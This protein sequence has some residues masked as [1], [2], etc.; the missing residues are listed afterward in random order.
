LYELDNWFVDDIQVTQPGGALYNASFTVYD[1][2]TSAV[3]EGAQVSVA[4]YGS[5]LTNS[6]GIVYFT[7]LANDDYVYT[8]N[9]DGYTEESG[10]FTVNNGNYQSIYLNINGKL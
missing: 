1:D 3:L 7:G 5:M 2:A 10:I 6:A 9:K 8:V 4:G